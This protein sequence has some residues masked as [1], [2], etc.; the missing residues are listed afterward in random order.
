MLFGRPMR[1]VRRVRALVVGVALAAT[2][3]V[4]A[5]VSAASTSSKPAV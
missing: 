4:A 5:S 2:V 1:P 3:V